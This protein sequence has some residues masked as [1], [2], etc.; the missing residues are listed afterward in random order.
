MNVLIVEDELQTANLLK[1][2]IQENDDFLV[3]EIVESIVDAVDYLS[4]HQNNLQLLFFDIQLSDGPSFEIFKHID[5]TTPVVFCTAYDD[6]AMEAIKNNGIDYILKPFKN[7]DIHQALEKY[8]NLID[9]YTPPIHIPFREEGPTYQRFF[10]GQFKQKTIVIKVEDIAFFS[11]QNEVTYL[12]TFTNKKFPVFKNLE[13]IETATSSDDFFR[14]NRQ[15]LLNRNAV[16]SYEPYFNRKIVLH[17]SVQIEEKPVVSRLKV[18]DFK[19]WLE[20]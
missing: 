13:H 5:I 8:R 1:E 12:H 6:Y 19:K 15:M 11:I 18:S 3:V 9:R 10:L 4:K 17:L 7:S 2:I 20:N 14:I 16:Q